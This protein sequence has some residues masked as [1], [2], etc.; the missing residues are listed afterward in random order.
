VSKAFTKDDGPGAPPIQRRRAP[1]PSGVANYVTARGLR[2]LQEELAGFDAA[3][4]AH[5]GAQSAP[6]R[7]ALAARR[8]ELEDRIA[9]AVVTAPPA[10]RDEV[11]FGARVRLSGAAGARE[12]EIVGVDEADPAAHRIAFTAPLARALL[13]RHVGEAVNVRSPGGEEELT[14]DEVSYG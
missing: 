12:L 4:A 7:Q 13:G 3:A 5:H 6:E 14:I 11:R 10:K 2:V 1:L 8:A 9:T